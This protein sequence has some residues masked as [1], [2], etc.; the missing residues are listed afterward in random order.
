MRRPLALSLLLFLAACEE[1]KPVVLRPADASVK[2][3]ALPTG[4]DTWRPTSMTGAPAPRRGATAVWT[5]SEMIVWGGVS[6]LLLSSGGRYD[7]AADAWRPMA[8]EGAPAGRV[9]H[10]AAWTG[11]EMIV[12]GGM[13]GF[14]P[15]ATGGRYDPATDTWRATATT[16]APTARADHT[17]VWTGSEVL[18]WG[19]QGTDAQPIG[20]RYEPVGD[21]WSAMSQVG[22][23][24]PRKR[25]QAGV[26]TGSEL[27]VWGGGDMPPL[28]RDGGRYKPTTDT[29]SAMPVDPGGFAQAAPEGRLD[30][31]AV[32]TG[33]ELV[34]WGGASGTAVF[35]V[36]GRYEVARDRWLAPPA[37]A[38]APS[39]RR[40]A[41]AAFT[42]AEMIVWGGAG[43]PQKIS[44]LGDGARFDPAVNAWRAMA[45]TGA[46]AARV[47][48]VAVWTGSE[49]VV[50]GGRDAEAALATGARYRP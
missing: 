15:L 28:P 9:Q 14:F 23:P 20:G 27:V 40:G 35:A 8:V 49:L 10:A 44:V 42:M 48:H 24:M 21:R 31:A 47:E 29:W 11:S 18:V 13:L 5:G 43:D 1:L 7:P 25:G 39:P 32:W 33:S 50:W 17:A 37:T 34:V 26:W 4:P 30:A 2:A 19:G 36:G 41:V 45:R 46:P 3:D 16:G 6:A 12:W 22:Q 38:D